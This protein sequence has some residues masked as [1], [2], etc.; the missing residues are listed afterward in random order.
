M[1]DKNAAAVIGGFVYGLFG[2]AGVTGFNIGSTFCAL[3]G[4]IILLGI[5]RA[6]GRPAAT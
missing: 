2:H 3:I 5:I 4:A 1:N 6:V